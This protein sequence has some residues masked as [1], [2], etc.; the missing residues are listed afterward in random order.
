MTRINTNVSSLIAQ[1]TL[2][3]SNADLQV[4]LNRL[5][6]GLRINVG[7]DD[8]A[9]LIASEA[10]RS[11]IL[12]VEKA[13]TNSERAN[14]VISTA[15]S[16]LGQVTNILNDIRG[17][18]TEAANAGALS[19]DQIAANQLQI[20]SSLEALNRIAQTTTF[21]GRRLL[22]GSLDFLT[23]AGTSFSRLTSLKIDQAN[24]GATGN[25]A[26]GIEVTT[27]ATK[28]LV[29]I[30][31]IP[32]ATSSANAQGSITFPDIATAS[33]GTLE[34]DTVEKQA[35]GTLALAGDTLTV[36]VLATNTLATG[37]AGND[38]DVNFINGVDG[39]NDVQ[40]ITWDGSTLA[41]TADLS[42]DT[43]LT[44]D[45]IAAAIS[46]YDFGGGAGVDFSVTSNGT[47]AAQ[48]AGDDL[49]ADVTSGGAD[50]TTHTLTITGATGTAANVSVTIQEATGVGAGAATLTGDATNGY[51]V[52][53]DDASAVSFA[54]IRDA[55]D[56]ATEIASVIGGAGNYDA[57]DGDTDLS[58]VGQ[59]ED[60]TGGADA[61]DDVITITAN[62]AGTAGNRTLSF[63]HNANVSDDFIGVTDDGS[64][65]T[66]TLDA[67]ST[68]S[69]SSLAS[70]IN[71]QLDDFTVS[72]SSSNGNGSFL[73]GTDTGTA[74]NV[75]GGV[76]ATGGL[77]N[78]LVIELAG[79]NG[80]E[81]LSFGAGTSIADLVAG[82]N[83]VKDATGVEAAVNATT[84]TTLDLQSTIYGSAGIVDLRVISEGSG[85][86][87]SGEF[88]TAVG[89]GERKAGLDVAAKVNGVTAKGDGNQ[90]SINTASL[91][92]T[93]TLDAG[94]TGSVGFT[95]AGG[96]ALFQLG[97]DVVTNQQARL[98]IQSVNT[99]RLGGT[100][101]LLY[102]VGSG[103][104]ASLDLDPTKA[105][106]IIDEAITQITS[107]R[108][109]LGAFQKTSLDTNIF[110]LQETLANLT[111]AESAIRDADFA[112]ESAALTR[113]QILVQSGTSVLSIANQNPQNVLALLR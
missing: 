46:T 37:A 5:S 77:T 64:T 7:K 22:D 86:S 32:G 25:V 62:A 99:A 95:I 48:I 43:T 13:I 41:I 30:G 39:G 63:V 60:L 85:S 71:S 110:T 31:N 18:V 36:T 68:Y 6:T 14:Q 106:E 112:K 2:A 109:R 49:N 15:D 27:A 113:A 35:S 10:L 98:G 26:V 12:G 96:G 55:I 52:L 33:G 87:P 111:E 88:T 61:G 74:A 56:D 94:F 11:D 1:K 73:A 66:V 51:V 101:G 57:T 102:E 3:R 108:G 82:I 59:T 90:I 21:Q 40:N 29:D 16:A 17:L 4:A 8:P 91:D 9:G 50:A 54:T 83:L 93:A 58:G 45:A 75:A 100:S 105:G 80:S 79:Y 69:L 47:A 84:A 65:I 23:T 78:D 42:A 97:P 104:A 81:V 34:I 107:L 28:G 67:G 44:T 103:G 70:T 19:D 92:L 38:I 72:L 76:D 24:L 53:V 89:Q 20:D